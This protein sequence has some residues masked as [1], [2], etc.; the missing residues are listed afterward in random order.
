MSAT[1][2]GLVLRI[3]NRVQGG[4]IAET[5]RAV[6]RAGDNFLA[7]RQPDQRQD[8]VLIRNQRLDQATAVV[9]QLPDVD[10]LVVPRRG[11]LVSHG[12]IGKAGQAI[13]GV[14][15]GV[16]TLTGSDVPNLDRTVLGTRSQP[17]P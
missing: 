1:T 3:S 14:A 10:R 12:G 13:R 11:E 2:S 6:R 15:Q 8:A 9:A 17:F 4:G 16:E 7:V 5:N